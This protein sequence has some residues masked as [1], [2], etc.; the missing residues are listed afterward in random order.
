MT[1]QSNFTQTK[2]LGD[3]AYE[4][5]RTSIITLKLHP[6][7]KIH[8]SDIAKSFNISRTPIRDAIHSLVSEQLIDILPQRTK[9]IA[10]ISKI[11]VIESAFV[12]WSLETSAFKQVT[13]EWG[14]SEEHQLV[15]KQIN[16]ILREQK[17]AAA[18]Q[19]MERF[20]Q[21]DEAFHK[22]ILQLSGNETLLRVIYLMRGHL[23]RFRYIAMKELQLTDRVIGEHEEL[24][25]EIKN[26][27]E[28]QVVQLLE[29]HMKHIDHEFQHLTKMFPSYFID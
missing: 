23:D 5:L 17:E 25:Q 10:C 14:N 26:Q 12:R 4:I 18:H 1:F 15:E 13:R 2:S 21:L 9:R 29:H 19:D 20:L 22:S 3:Q 8:E 24:F 6:G 7:Q 28:R 16:R 27:N 11:K